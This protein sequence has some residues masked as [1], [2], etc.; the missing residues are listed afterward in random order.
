[1]ASYNSLNITNF[2]KIPTD[3]PYRTRDSVVLRLLKRIQHDLDSDIINQL[4][5]NK[6]LLKVFIKIDELL[7]LLAT[8]ASNSNSVWNYRLKTPQKAT[9][10]PPACSLPADTQRI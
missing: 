6:L 10:R 2:Y 9:E 5:N 7:G 1:M 8:V 4:E 3:T